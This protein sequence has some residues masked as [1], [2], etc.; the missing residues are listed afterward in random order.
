MFSEGPAHRE[1]VCVSVSRTRIA[2]MQS[3]IKVQRAFTRGVWVSVSVRGS[4]VL[5]MC[6]HVCLCVCLVRDIGQQET[7][8]VQGRGEGMPKGRKTVVF[9]F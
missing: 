4:R 3:I 1:R 9:S 5:C 6:M 8:W 7:G 2:E